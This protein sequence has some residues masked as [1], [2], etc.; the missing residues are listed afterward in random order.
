MPIQTTKY[1]KNSPCG[2]ARN[3]PESTGIR[4]STESV[5]IRKPQAN[6]RLSFHGDECQA[7]KAGPGGEGRGKQI[8]PVVLS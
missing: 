3:P 5:R 4:P 8:L 2:A 7:L 1:A 6:C